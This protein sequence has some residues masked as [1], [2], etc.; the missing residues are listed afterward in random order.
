M[1]ASEEPLR[2][3]VVFIT[4]DP[5][6]PVVGHLLSRL[7]IYFNLLVISDVELEES[8]PFRTQYYCHKPSMLAKISLLFFKNIEVRAEANFLKRNVY[9]KYRHLLHI[10]FLLK[11]VF[12]FFFRLPLY[13]EICQFLYSTNYQKHLTG[14]QQDDVCITD[15][16]LRHVRYLIPVIVAAKRQS[17]HLCSLVYSFDN[18]HYSTLNTF[19][20]SYIVWNEVNKRELKTFYAIPENKIFI[21]ASLIID[22]LLERGLPA[23]PKENAVSNSNTTVT[24]LYSAV[25]PNDDHI[26]SR[27]EEDFIFDLGQSIFDENP[28]FRLIVRPYPNKGEFQTFKKLESQPWAEVYQHENFITIP[29]LG[30]DQESL[31]FNNSPAEKIK[32]FFEVDGFISAGSTYT[33]EFA[34]S[35]RP[36]IHLDPRKFE[37]NDKN[38][39]FFERMELFEHL[40]I[41]ADPRFSANL[42]SNKKELIEYTKNLSAL[43]ETGYNQFL[44][45]FG[46]FD[47][48][49]LA[50]DRVVDFVKSIK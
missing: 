12:L 8:F 20:D 43:A 35:G 41:F 11:N 21:S 33:I 50:S 42:P 38:K 2:K 48:S 10:F 34:F 7:S 40:D 39:K 15:A 5:L 36:I 1:Q 30:N 16:N 37:R 22:Y 47:I 45:D 3:R 4:S 18:T 27:Y 25:N 32:Q 13:S 19:S 6:N 24:L 29:R 17:K 44:I 26:M 14:I 31:S 23:K 9:S 49:R 28:R 46:S